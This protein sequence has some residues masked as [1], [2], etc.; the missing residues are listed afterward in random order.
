MVWTHRAFGKLKNVYMPERTK[1]TD[2]GLDKLEAHKKALESEDVQEYI[3]RL[4][5]ELD[6]ELGVADKAGKAQDKMMNE[7]GSDNPEK[8]VPRDVPGAE[9]SWEA[10]KEEA[11]G[12]A[13]EK[14][15]TEVVEEFLL[16]KV[17]DETLVFD[18]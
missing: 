9:A 14:V 2:A 13:S 5:T 11:Q 4:T 1:H 3:G 15:L 10:A 7:M 18:Q 17:D 16:Q 12:K 8:K 6:N